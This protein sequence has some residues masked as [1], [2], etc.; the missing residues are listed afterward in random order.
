MIREKDAVETAPVSSVQGRAYVIASDT[1]LLGALVGALRGAGWEATAFAA[2]ADLT[3]RLDGLAPGCIVSG[4]C[5]DSADGAALLGELAARAC[6]F[7][8]VALA[9]AGDVALAVRAMKAGAADVVALPLQPAVL[10]EAARSAMAT[11]SAPMREGPVPEGVR[12]RLERLTRRER[13]VLE[14]IVR[15]DG[16][17]VI[18]HDLGIS[19]RTVEVHRSK[20]MEKLSCRS[21]SDVIRLA[22]QARLLRA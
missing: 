20:V 11:W 17:K 3:A 8:V 5:V 14:S 16:N 2:V 15:G 12:L 6:P 22:M 13:Q 19:P 9:P 1:Q 7:P 21:L 4:M 18:A 10:A